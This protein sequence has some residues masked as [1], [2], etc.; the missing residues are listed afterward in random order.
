MRGVRDDSERQLVG[1]SVN[2]PQV[3]TFGTAGAQIQF[4]LAARICTEHL[5]ILIAAMTR[6]LSV[7]L[8]AAALFLASPLACAVPVTWIDA[9]DP[10]DYLVAAPGQLNFTHDITGSGFRP[11]IDAVLAALLTVVLYDDSDLLSGERVSFS[12]DSGAWTPARNVGDGRIP[13]LQLIVPD[14]V[15]LGV[16]SFLSDGLVNVRLQATVGDF[17][18]ARS[19]LV[20]AGIRA[21]SQARLPEPGTLAV[22]GAVLLAPALLLTWRQRRETARNLRLPGFNYSKQPDHRQ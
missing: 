18:F 6:T 12:F 9:Y 13:L 3:V 8:F 20:V 14:V 22:F 5:F 17:F 2:A 7:K 21:S 11:G 4:A 10:D 1:I 15:P 16:T 19:E